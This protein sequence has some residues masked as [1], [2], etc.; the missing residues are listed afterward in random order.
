MG[1]IVAALLGSAG[2]RNFQT[3]VVVGSAFYGA[4]TS[5]G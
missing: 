5:A 3:S 2:R 4:F 1:S